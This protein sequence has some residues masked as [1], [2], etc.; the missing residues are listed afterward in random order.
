M[1]RWRGIKRE[2]RKCTDCDS[3]EVEDVTHFLMRCNA[4]NGEREELMEKL[5]KV[6]S[7]GF[8]EVEEERNVAWIVD[9][10]CR[11]ESNARGVQKSWR[12]KFMQK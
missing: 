7:A 12:E 5:K 9:L 4:W 3:G 11:N 2:E 10:T 1:G 8:D 6:C